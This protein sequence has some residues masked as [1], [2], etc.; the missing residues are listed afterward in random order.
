[1]ENFD[2]A[3]V[4]QDSRIVFPL[5]EGLISLRIMFCLDSLHQFQSQMNVE[6]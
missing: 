6:A 4:F 1:M 2:S 5:L 3:A